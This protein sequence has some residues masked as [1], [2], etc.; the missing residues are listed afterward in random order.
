MLCPVCGKVNPNRDDNQYHRGRDLDVQLVKLKK[1]IDT[2]DE[3]EEEKKQEV[4]DLIKT[5]Q[6]KISPSD[7]GKSDLRNILIDIGYWIRKNLP[8]KEVLEFNR[9]ERN[10]LEKLQQLVKDRGVVTVSSISEEFN[11]VGN[12][13]EFAKRTCSEFD[14]IELREGKDGYFLTPTG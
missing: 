9:F 8:E 13:T 14:E 7:R 2:V 1:E 10:Q 4:F 11:F 6:K 5:L 3:I 12:S